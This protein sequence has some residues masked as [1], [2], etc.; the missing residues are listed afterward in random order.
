VAFE[1]IRTERLIIRRSR[2]SDAQAAYERRSLPEVAR[3]Q[4]WEMPYTLERAQQNMAKL[5]AMDGPV[6]GTGWSA[7]VVDAAEPDTILGDLY[8]GIKWGGRSAEIGYTFHPD[9]W[10][11]GY[12]TEAAQAIVRYLFDEVGVTR[13]ESSAHPDNP[14]SLRVME[15]CGMLYEG[16]TR[17]SFWV[18]DECSD[19]IF[20][21]MTRSDWDAWVG[22]PR[23]RPD[24]VRLVAITNENHREVEK[25]ATHKS[26]E[27]FVAPVLVSFSDALSPPTRG[28]KTVVPWYRAIEA[29]GELVGFIMATEPTDER[30]TPYLWR[31]LVD[32]M[33]QRRGVGSM[34]LDLFEQWC[35]DRGATEVDVS[36][37]PGPGSPEPMYLGRGYQPSGKVDDGEIHGVK[38]LA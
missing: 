10:G 31:L 27:E 23:H 29:D 13:I 12:A 5:V 22:R 19:D 34:A 16:L 37:E 6:D 38:R 9:H 17:H 24:E 3:Y 4:D 32:R 35:R 36:W 25:L 7:T 33:H 8:V 11:R 15:A 14:P 20:Y 28:G 18:G 1:P 30:P 26:Q 21:G 2:L